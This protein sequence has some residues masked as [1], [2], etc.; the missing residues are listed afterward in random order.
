MGHQAQERV[1]SDRILNHL[2]QGKAKESKLLCNPFGAGCF[3]GTVRSDDSN[4]HYSMSGG[5]KTPSKG[6]FDNLF[7]AKNQTYSRDKK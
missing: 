1:I 2:A 7:E 4:V 6:C 3:T 5:R